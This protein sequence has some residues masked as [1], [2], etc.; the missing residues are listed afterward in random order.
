V[1]DAGFKNVRFSYKKSAERK[2]LL[3]KAMMRVMEN[4]NGSEIEGTMKTVGGATGSALFLARKAPGS[5]GG[6]FMAQELYC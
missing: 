1:T 5:S 3:A 2:Q 6:F 4:N